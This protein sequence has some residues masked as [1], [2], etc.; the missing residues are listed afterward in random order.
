[1]NDQANEASTQQ[2][3]KQINKLKNETA[4]KLIKQIQNLT[5]GFIT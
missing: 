5:N 4:L 3:N 1:M 2:I